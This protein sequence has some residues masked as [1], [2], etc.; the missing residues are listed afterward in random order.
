MTVVEFQDGT[1]WPVFRN[2][3]GHITTHEMISAKAFFTVVPPLAEGGE[4]QRS[5]AEVLL[6]IHFDVLCAGA[7]VN[8]WGVKFY[9]FLTYEILQ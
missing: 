9:T 8:G 5:R 1:I 3:M 2:D 6:Q 7:G 4:Q